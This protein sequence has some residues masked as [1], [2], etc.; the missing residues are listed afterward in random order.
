MK[1][2]WQNREAASYPN[3]NKKHDPAIQNATATQ[4]ANTSDAKHKRRQ[5]LNDLHRVLRLLAD[6]RV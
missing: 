3:A 2:T 1:M 4:T 5:G 6:E